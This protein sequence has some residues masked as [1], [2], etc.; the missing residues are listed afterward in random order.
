MAT[1][2]IS[3]NSGKR[4]PESITRVLAVD[5]VA[6]SGLDVAVYASE[7]ERAALAEACGLASV[8]EF[9]ASLHVRKLDRIRFNVTG[10]LHARVTQTCVV[11]LEPFESSVEAEIDVDFAPAQAIGQLSHQK[12]PEGGSPAAV[13][14]AG[15]DPPDPIVDGKI[16][17]GA[18]ATE[19][20]VL[21]LDDYP[22]KP[23]VTFDAPDMGGDAPE[24]NSPFAILRRRP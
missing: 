4:R 11:S 18:L 16:D 12:I 7:A 1:R 2:T 6:E 19:F 24:E 21:N 9:V 10:N 13:F 5:T 22:R 15:D 17:L 14:Q 3:P 20:L 8:Q 23:G